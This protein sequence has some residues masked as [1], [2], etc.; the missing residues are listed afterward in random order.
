MQVNNFFSKIPAW[1]L[2][3][4]F[5]KNNGLPLLFILLIFL[6]IFDM[7]FTIS[8]PLPIKEKRKMAAKPQLQLSRLWDSKK[9]YEDYFND[10]FGFRTHLLYYHNLFTVKYFNT[11][12]TDKVLLGRQGWLFMAKETENRN[13]VNY[14]RA[15]KPFTAVELREWRQLLRQRWAWLKQRGIAYLFV[16]VPNKSTIYPEYMPAAIR[17]LHRQS[18][19]D[20]LL[21]ALQEEGGFPTIDLRETLL[22]AKRSQRIYHKTD[23]HWNELGAYF[24]YQ[25]VM[26]KLAKDFPDLKVAALN[27][28]SIE[29]R[30]RMGGD[31]AL[32]LALQKKVFREQIITLKPLAPSPAI[33]VREGKKLAGFVRESISECPSGTLPTALMVHDSFIH[34]LRPLLNPHFKRIIYIWDARLNFYPDIV[35]RENPKIVIEEMTERKLEDLQLQN[36]D[37]P[38]A[39]KAE[40][41]ER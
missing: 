6:P 20:Q 41:T 35:R 33:T 14:F 16:I 39:T 32:M 24:A 21:E 12:P 10:N 8:Q 26:E 22:V 18:R 29:R 30:D 27:E 1:P 4:N 15:L 25:K 37:F 7:V 28:F 34:Q 5:K 19:M 38:G 9:K 23:S 36:P 11:S 13:T 17:R 40:A 2:L 31:L 3:F